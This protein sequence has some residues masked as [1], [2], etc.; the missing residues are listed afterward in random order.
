MKTCP[1][2]QTL[3]Q[4]VAV[5]LSPAEA[6]ELIEHME[7]CAA[8]SE[9]L[10]TLKQNRRTDIAEGF[11]DLRNRKI[12]TSSTLPKRIDKYEVVAKIGEGGM[13]TVYRAWHPDLQR[14][15][16]V[17]VLK[18]TRLDNA[19]ARSRFSKEIEAVGRLRHENI[20]QAL[21]AGAADGVPFITME[22]LDGCDLDEYVTKNGPLPVEQALSL[23]RQAATGLA[24]AH[25][26]G[27]IHRDVK[28]SNLFLTSNGIVKLLDL[29]IAQPIGSENRETKTETGHVVG[30]PEFMA[31]EQFRG[32]TVDVR[33]D[34]YSLGCTLA[35]LLTGKPLSE[36]HGSLPATVRPLVTKMTAGMPDQRFP[37]TGELIAAIDAIQKRKFPRCYLVPILAS[38]AAT[39]IAGVLVTSGSPSKDKEKPAN[40]AT[41]FVTNQTSEHPVVPAA[42]FI[43]EQKSEQP[44]TPASPLVETKT[45]EQDGTEIVK[46]PVSDETK[47]WFAEYE[48]EKERRRIE[49]AEYE[50]AKTEAKKNGTQITQPPLSAPFGP[51]PPPARRMP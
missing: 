13:G 46:S 18:E 10:S 47:K 35:Y 42:P 45:K 40:P 7:S 44:A 2:L 41:P 32:G 36:S 37:S 14:D 15:V 25:T 27:L 29:G 21:D 34:I 3:K 49:Y 11:R 39:V 4:F 30:S 28:P 8:C 24:H 50:K 12:E 38:V 22:L 1:S 5:T 43:D 9:R 20:V 16:A 6:A 31:P 33:S 23:V 26:V 48:K 51:I 17:K 19:M